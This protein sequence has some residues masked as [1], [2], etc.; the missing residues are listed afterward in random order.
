MF[1]SLFENACCCKGNHILVNLAHL[2]P[3]R[4]QQFKVQWIWTSL[5]IP[6]V[7]MYTYTH[8][9][10]NNQGSCRAVPSWSYIPRRGSCR[11]WSQASPGNGA[12]VLAQEMLIG[13]A[14]PQQRLSAPKAKPRWQPWRNLHSSPT[15]GGLMIREIWI[16]SH[17]G[18]LGVWPL[19][20]GLRAWLKNS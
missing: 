11:L 5:Q 9:Q 3:V 4:M 1:R 6:D 18:D 17:F 10:F 12:V 13:R 2:C 16:P 19:Q 14:V 7:Y 15:P 20:S 8:T